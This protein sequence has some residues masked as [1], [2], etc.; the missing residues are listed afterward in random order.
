MRK[1]LM[2]LV[3]GFSIACG[4]GVTGSSTTTGA[5]SLRTINNTS[6][7]YTIVGSSN[8]KTEILDDVITLYQ[9][10]TYAESGHSRT[11]TNGQVANGS[12]SEAGSYS[13]FGTSLTLRSGDGART[14]ISTIDG[15]T[16]T[17]V[18]SGMLSV[19]AK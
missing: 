3:V 7:P 6:L 1:V 11:T 15:N 8:V 13:T 12:N 17:I 10:G 4:D 9:G 18:E 2:V 19:F 16:M 14:R 5:Y